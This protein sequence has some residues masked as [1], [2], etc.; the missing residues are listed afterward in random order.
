MGGKTIIGKKGVIHKF[1]SSAFQLIE[2]KRRGYACPLQRRGAVWPDDVC[3]LTKQR[4]A[5][6]ALFA[7]ELRVC[8]H[9]VRMRFEVVCTRAWHRLVFLVPPNGRNTR[10]SLA[11]SGNYI[12]TTPPI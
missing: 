4:G 1:S 10:H 5:H 8:R 6:C 3:L 9:C 2:V 12:I 7:W 11:P